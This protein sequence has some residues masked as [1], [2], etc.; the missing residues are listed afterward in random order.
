[1]PI[2]LVDVSLEYKHFDNPLKRKKQCA[3]GLLMLFNFNLIKRQVMR[4]Q[5]EFAESCIPKK[6]NG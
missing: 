4:K 2:P 1:M 5:V 3:M 6:L